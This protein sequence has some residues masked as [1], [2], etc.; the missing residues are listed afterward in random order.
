MC[1]EEVDWKNGEQ[2]KYY[3][4]LDYETVRIG[5]C[6]RFIENDIYF[7]DVSILERAIEDIGKDNLRDNYFVE[8]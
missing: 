7:A 4:F 5:A 6:T 8:A 2:N 3:V 1:K